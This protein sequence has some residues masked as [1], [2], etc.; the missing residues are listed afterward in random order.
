[1]IQ[2]LGAFQISQALYVVAKLGLSTALVDGPRTVEDLAAATGAKADVIGRIIRVLA[3]MGVFRTDGGKVESTA[4]GLTLAEGYPG[5]VRDAALFWME[6]HYAPF[7]ELLHTAMTGEN[8][9]THY[10]GKP[11][12]D[13]TSSNP[14]MADIQTR[15]MA[16]LTHALRAGMFEGYSL[17]EGNLVADIGGADGSMICQFLAREP[18]R[19]GIV[20]DRPE[21]VPSARKVLADHGLAGRVSI[22]SGDFF[23]SVP[24]ADVYILSYV[25]HDWDDESCLRILQTIKN[26]AAPGARL[27]LVESVIPPGDTPHPAK[28]IDLT[29]LAMTTGRERTAGEYE[30]LLAAAGFTMD[31]IVPSPTMFSFIEAT[32]P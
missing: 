20:F 25:F 14:A 9:A 28:L 13:W 2:M 16:S 17:P 22:Q 30:R 12:M 15:T 27:V 32:L 8:A 6:S 10:Y 23:E 5:S 7:G 4:L 24:T 18:D 26:A 19:R 1:M 3:P 29:M 21:I 11:F 31:G